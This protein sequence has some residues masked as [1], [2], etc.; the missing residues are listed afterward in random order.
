MRKSPNPAAQWR[1]SA[2]ELTRGRSIALCA[3]ALLAGT[4][5]WADFARAEETL[6]SIFATFDK[7]GDGIID[8][9]EYDLNKVLVIVALDADRDDLLSPA[10]VKLSQE[11]FAAMDMDGDGKISGF[12]FVESDLGKFETIDTDGDGNITVEEL[13]AYILLLRT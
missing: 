7:N 11:K 3:L 1:A 8:R 10:E 9:T 4:L 2:A 12:E 13:R 5:L 6:E